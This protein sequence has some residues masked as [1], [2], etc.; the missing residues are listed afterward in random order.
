MDAAF[1]GAAP[2]LQA[3][4]YAAGS[5]RYFVTDALWDRGIRVTSAARA[6]AIP[7][8]EYTLAA[9]LFSLK[10]AWMLARRMK[11]QQRAPARPRV[12]GAFGS[13]VGIVGLGLIGRLVRERL[14]PFDL[15][16]L[17]SDP[18]TSG[19]QAATLG[20]E[21]ASLEELFRSADVVSLH[22]PLLPETIG[23]VRGRH[24][25]SMKAGATFINTARGALVAEDE[26]I[27]ALSQR[28]DLQAILDVT[29]PEPPAAGSRLYTLPNVVLTP[30]IAGA[31]DGECRRLGRMM[32]EELDRYLKGLP[33]VG[34]VRREQATLRA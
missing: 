20:V 22:A 28:P 1:L 33:L 3:V 2:N 5:V 9:I 14:R 21:L 24:L 26:M 10:S 17:A 8:A 34:E 25:E 7:V 6:N 15:R 32:V 12:A 11:A 16:V 18:L 13:V 23:M 30:H 4:F 19:E 27:D 29:D 31:L